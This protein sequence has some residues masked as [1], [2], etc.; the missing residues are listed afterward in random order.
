MVDSEME[1]TEIEKSKSFREIFGR[2]KTGLYQNSKFW[3]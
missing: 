2:P 1:K 3:C